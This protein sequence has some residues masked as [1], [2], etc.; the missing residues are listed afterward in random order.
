MSDLNINDYPKHK[1]AL[2]K[3]IL[4]AGGNANFAKYLKISNQVVNAWLNILEKGAPVKRCPEIEKMTNGQVTCKQLRPDFFLTEEKIADL[5]TEEKV[6]KC[7]LL[8]KNI[9][10]ELIERKEIKKSSGA[11]KRNK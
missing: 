9:Y 8:M 3:A 6:K 1:H 5:D 11:K 4:I 7:M 10:K 2:V